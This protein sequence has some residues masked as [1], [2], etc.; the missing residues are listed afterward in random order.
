MVS[1]TGSLL[2]DFD[3]DFR[4]IG[5][6]KVGLVLQTGR[7]GAVAALMRVAEFVEIEQFGRQ[8]LAARMSLTLVLVARSLLRTLLQVLRSSY[9]F[10]GAGRSTALL[11]YSLLHSLRRCAVK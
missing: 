10:D 6:R 8:R 7:H 4:T 3:R 5:F 9:R 1:R 2:G 11:S